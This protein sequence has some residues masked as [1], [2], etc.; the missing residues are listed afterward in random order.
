MMTV[1][2]VRRFVVAVEVVQQVSVVEEEF[3]DLERPGRGYLY[4]RLVSRWAA[5]AMPFCGQ[6]E[7]SGVNS[8]AACGVPDLPS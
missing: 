8:S 1:R 2:T 4:G 7:S 6:N 5:A 3:L